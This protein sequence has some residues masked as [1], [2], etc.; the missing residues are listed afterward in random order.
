[1]FLVLTEY[2]QGFYEGYL[3]TFIQGEVEPSESKGYA[4][5]IPAAH[6]PFWKYLDGKYV[7]SESE[8]VHGSAQLVGGNR[9]CAESVVHHQFACR[10]MV[11][12]LAEHVG[13]YASVAPWSGFATRHGPLNASFPQGA[14]F[15][16]FPC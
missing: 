3:P 10:E 1:M 7:G 4:R 14:D 15:D 11:S 5:R 16:Q 6:D 9:D 2:V 8:P 12:E 13:I